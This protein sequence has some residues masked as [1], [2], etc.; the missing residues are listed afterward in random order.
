MYPT[1]SEKP[2]DREKWLKKD[3]SLPT[4]TNPMKQ[5]QVVRKVQD[6][7]YQIS[8]EVKKKLNAFDRNYEPLHKSVNSVV[9]ILDKTWQM[10]SSQESVLCVTHC[11]TLVYSVLQGKNQKTIRKHEQNIKWCL[12]NLLYYGRH[13]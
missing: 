3:C 4:I 5:Q 7:Y 2:A 11:I 10:Q 1:E 9:N 12:E 6:E 8:I 13:S